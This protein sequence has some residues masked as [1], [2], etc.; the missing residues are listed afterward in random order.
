ML[1]RDRAND[2]QEDRY[3]QDAGRDGAEVTLED[4]DQR[5]LRLA[6][7]ICYAVR[8]RDEEADDHEQARRHRHVV[9]PDHGERRDGPGVV[10]LLGQIRG[11]LPADEAVQ[12]EQRGQHEAV[13][14]RP[15]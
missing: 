10:G 3:L 15:A 12:R 11:A 7:D 5:V 8:D 4:V 6:E 1:S 2:R 9:G 13:P 14:E